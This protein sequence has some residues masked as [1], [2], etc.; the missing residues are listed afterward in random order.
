M[1]RPTVGYLGPDLALDEVRAVLADTADVIVV[2]LDEQALADA[3][4]GLDGLVDASTRIPLGADALAT[5]QRLRIVSLASTGSSHVDAAGAA[6]AGIEVHTLRED[7]DLLAELTPA[8]EHTWAL[9][10][11]CA[12]RL[13]A[14]A[15]HVEGGGWE[16]E[17]FPGMMLR[18]RR[19]GIVGLGRIGGWVARYG[20]A[21]GMDVVAH[22]PARD[23]W[24]DGIA[25]V[26]LEELFATSDVIT[27]H[28]HLDDAT[29][30][31]VSRDLME[32]CAPST[33][34][35]NTARGGIV[36][37]AALLDLL[38]AGRLGAAGLDVL[39]DE[40]PGAEHPMVAAAR[41]LDTLIVTPH[42][43]GYSPDAVRL[44]CRRAAGKVRER[45]RTTGDG[46]D[47]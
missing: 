13:P 34:V 43:G 9:V 11:A 45:L 36:D 7:R 40:P 12:R 4:P 33:I 5:A 2:P 27:V 16:R 32:R 38:R 29:R 18:G 25:R 28:V 1:P 8:A 14:A 39:R 46:P 44:V 6:A 30:G 17:G 31:L 24:P 3:V 41:E 35:V 26:D 22:D 19:L 21:F 47:A 20:A 37:E 23:P 42:I 15:S 10:L